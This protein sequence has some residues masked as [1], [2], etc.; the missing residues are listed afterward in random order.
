MDLS[1]DLLALVDVG[2]LIG[3]RR[4]DGAVGERMEDDAAPQH[5]R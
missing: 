3:E 4:F 2:A 5:V 1:I